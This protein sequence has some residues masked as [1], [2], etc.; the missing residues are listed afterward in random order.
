MTLRD[1]LLEIDGVGE[2]TADKIEAVVAEHSDAEDRDAMQ[3][4]LLFHRRG[5]PDI[6]AD[7]LES[8]LE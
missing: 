3:R 1:E 5:K 6:A 4:A 7:V 2:V 8:A